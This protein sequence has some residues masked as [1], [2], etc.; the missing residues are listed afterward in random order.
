MF[1]FLLFICLLEIASLC[2]LAW[3]KTH[4]VNQIGLELMNDSPT[5]ASLTQCVPSLLEK[6]SNGISNIMLYK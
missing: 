6:C 3:P 5:S 2:R 4:Q 1:L